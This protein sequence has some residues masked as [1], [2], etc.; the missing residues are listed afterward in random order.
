M[1]GTSAIGRNLLQ[2][3]HPLP[4]LVMTKWHGILTP[5]LKFSWRNMWDTNISTI[6]GEF[7]WLIWHR[8]VAINL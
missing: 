3:K 7:I 5:R 1:N 4:K 2:S 8:V 6:E